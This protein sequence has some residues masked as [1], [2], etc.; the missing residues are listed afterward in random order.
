MSLSDSTSYQ[1]M[2]SLTRYPQCGDPEKL[3]QNIDSFID[4][5][6]STD[7]CFLFSPSQIALSAVV[8]AASKLEINLDPSNEIKQLQ[9]VMRKLWSMITSVSTPQREQVRAIEQKLEL[10]RNQSNNPDSKDYQRSLD[11]EMGEETV[12]FEQY[13]RIC[14]EQERSDQKLIETTGMSSKRQKF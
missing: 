2:V 12:P 5:S 3:R 4:L 13:A 8:Y 14:Q 6:L 11:E 9:K 1:R 7:A 10:C